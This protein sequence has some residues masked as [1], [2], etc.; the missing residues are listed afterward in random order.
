MT[1]MRMNTNF[2]NISLISLF[3]LSWYHMNI[4]EISLIY[5][6][7]YICSLNVRRTENQKIFWYMETY[8]LF[9]CAKFYYL[10]NYE[11][12]TAAMEYQDK[13]LERNLSDAHLKCRKI[14]DMALYSSILF[15]F[16]EKQFPY[17]YAL[18]A[19]AKYIR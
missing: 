18:K 10:Y 6:Y 16:K 8:F 7:I 15:Y 4:F 3:L 9:W 17:N 11:Y 19:K 5:I 1:V 12:T 2:D 14:L 13:V